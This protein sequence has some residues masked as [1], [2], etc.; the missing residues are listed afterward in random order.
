M[1]K[2]GILFCSRSKLYASAANLK[3]V[4]AGDFS[5]VQIAYG[6]I[7]DSAS[8]TGTTGIYLY[9]ISQ[10]SCYAGA[11]QGYCRIRNLNNGIYAAVGGK[12]IGTSNNQYSGNTVDENAIAASFGYID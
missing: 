4:S 9:G 11:A 1:E 7:I 8:V 3:G 12:A 5:L 10:A 6:T 2:H